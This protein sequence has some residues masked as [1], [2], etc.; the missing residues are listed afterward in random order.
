MRIKD[1]PSQIT[2]RVPMPT[3]RTVWLF[4]PGLVL[5]IV[6]GWKG[7]VLLDAA[8]LG[9]CVIDFAMIIRG[10]DIKASRHCPRRLSQGVPHDFEIRLANPGP[11]TKA[12]QVRDQTPAGW[13]AAP[14]LERVLPGRSST[15]LRYSLV[16]GDRGEH[17][18]GNLW[19]RIQGPLGLVRKPL[20]IP[21][22]LVVEV[23]PCL[24]TL[25][26]S[27][28]STYRRV[29]RNWGL[30]PSWKSREGR[31][32]ESLRDYVEGDDP[33]KM[34]WKA[35]ARL[36]RPIVQDFQIERNQIVML[37]VDA[38]R[39][40]T[41]FSEGKTKL[42]HAL[43]AAIQLAHMALSGGDLVGILAFAGRVISF[44]PPRRTSGQLQRLMQESLN[45]RP[46][47]V[48]SQYENAVL[49]LQSRV[50]RRSLVV[51]YT[52]LI[53]EVASEALLGAVGL[54][55]PRHLPLC[56][57]IADSEWEDLL[58]HPPEEVRG[59][60]ERSVLQGLLRQRRKALWNMVQKGALTLD[61]PP[62]RLSAGTL[63]R[64]LE[65]KRRGLL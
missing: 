9:L 10:G 49:W 26:Y 64:Y 56:V 52:D 22:S 50:R 44:V 60:Y 35:T 58:T 11:S 42:D 47:L 6:W 32:F 63:E 19:I 65:V 34:H 41:A 5:A 57:A 4:A 8:V 37:L 25:R 61:L 33:R 45:L 31:E 2:I 27:D 46:S 28:V 15:K 7:A 20:V 21:S 13:V 62:S 12:V 16:P 29:T 54:L 38:G 48:D 43:E 40:M 36:D 53:D 55:R 30:R 3:S 17:K 59:V 18:F 39:L 51:I 1:I 24:Q 23:Y 14:V